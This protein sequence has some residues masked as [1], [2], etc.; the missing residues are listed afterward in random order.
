MEL[1]SQFADLDLKAVPDI[2]DANGWVF[3]SADV[4]LLRLNCILDAGALRVMLWK[5]YGT[6][7]CLHFLFLGFYPSF[8][9]CPTAAKAACYVFHPAVNV[10]F[11]QFTG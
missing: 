5:N 9:A 3:L 8:R 2:E 11:P 4:V 10:L 7:E 6:F 1:C